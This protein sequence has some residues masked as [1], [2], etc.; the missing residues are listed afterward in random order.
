MEDQI[1]KK[2]AKEAKRVREWHYKNGTVAKTYCYNTPDLIGFLGAERFAIY[3]Y[4]NG[5]VQ[6]NGWCYFRYEDLIKKL[7][8]SRQRISKILRS[9]RAIGVIIK[10]HMVGS[11][12][13]YYTISTDALDKIFMTMNEFCNVEAC[14]LMD[15]L[16]GVNLNAVSFEYI[17]TLI[18]KNIPEAKSSKLE[19]SND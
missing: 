16:E 1:L 9:L 19:L 7:R 3:S 14:M 2:D 13:V 11:N 17:K 8:F 5:F 15:E 6:M 18:L 4:I 10:H 12:N